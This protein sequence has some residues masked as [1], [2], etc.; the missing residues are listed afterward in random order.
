MSVGDTSSCWWKQIQ[1]EKVWRNMEKSL[2]PHWTNKISGDN[3]SDGYDE[4]YMKSKS[5][6]NCMA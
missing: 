6:S 2:R 1:H 4:K 3:N 5:N